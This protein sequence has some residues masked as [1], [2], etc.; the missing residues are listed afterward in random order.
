MHAPFYGCSLA[1]S[2]SIILLLVIAIPIM[3]V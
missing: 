2:L 3:T 1:K